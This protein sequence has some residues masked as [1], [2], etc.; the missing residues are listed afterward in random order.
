MTRNSG[1]RI[2][3]NHEVRDRNAHMTSGKPTLIYSPG[4]CSLAPHIVLEEL[5]LPFDLQAVNTD[6]GDTRTGAFA[7]VNPKGRVPVLIEGDAV[8]TEAPAILLHLAQKSDDGWLMPKGP[9]EL[10]RTLEWYNWLSGTVHSVAIRQIWRSGYFTAADEGHEPIRDKGHQHLKQAFGLIEKRQSGEWLMPSGY[11]VLDPYL[12]VFYRWGNR[13]DYD[14][15]TAYPA[16]TEHAQ[17][18]AKRP[19]VQKALATEQIDL[20]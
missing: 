17:R 20:W 3:K 19:A 14:M 11:T 18:M 15:R 13:L 7:K 9:E 12:L 4:S 8:Y 5:D 16:W 6:R 1:P 2:A 10:V